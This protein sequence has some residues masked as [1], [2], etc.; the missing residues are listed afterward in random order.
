[1]KTP[2]YVTNSLRKSILIIEAE[3]LLG[4]LLKEYIC[5]HTDWNVR[6]ITFHV[7]NAVE[8]CQ[9]QK[10]DVVIVSRHIK[11]GSAGFSLVTKLRENNYEGKIVL[12]SPIDKPEMIQEAI[13]SGASAFISK[14]CAPDTFLNV[15]QTLILEEADNQFIVK[16]DYLLD[17]YREQ[18]GIDR[19]SSLTDAEREVLLLIARGRT[20][21]EIAFDLQKAHTT[22]YSHQQHIRDK[23][24]IHR[25]SDLFSLAV[26]YYLTTS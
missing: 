16:P 24:D 19:Y 9:S 13:A 6:S 14:H 21:K 25:T 18:K 4:H 10:P 23:F 12:L 26:D 1:M 11:D 7:Y 20:V 22:I 3:A 8:A 2:T 15:I 17:T 5:Q